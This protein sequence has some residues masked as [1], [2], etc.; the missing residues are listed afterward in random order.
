MSA[1]RAEK[2]I[3]AALVRK[4]IERLSR[5]K[6]DQFYPDTGP[7]RRELYKPHMACFA[8]GA[9]YRERLVLAANR[10]GKTESIGL[11]ELTLHLTGEYPT[12]WVGCRFDRPISAWACGDTGKTVREILQ[13]KLLGPIGQ[14]GTGLIPGDLIE[15]VT[16][17]SGVADSVDSIFVKHVSGL[18]SVLTLKSYDQREESFR[19]TEKDFILLDEEPPMGI[20]IECLM[21]TMTNNGK[22]L[23]TFTPL[24]GTS[25]VVLAFL[26]GGSVGAGIAQNKCVVMAEWDDVPHL[27]E[28]DKAEMLTKI[29][30]YQRDARS[31]GLPQLGAGAI[32]PVAESDFAVDDFPVPAHWLRVFGLD[33]GWR[34]TACVWAAQD[35][36]TRTWYLY[37][38]HYEGLAE[39]SEIAL[40][41]MARGSRI[42]GV[43]DPAARGR[44]PSDGKQLLSMYSDLGLDLTPADNSVHSGIN[45]TWDALSGGSLKVFKS[46]VNWF[47]EFRVYQRDKNGKI[48]KARDHLMD[49]C[50]TADT[51]V[52]TADG[53]TPWPEARQDQRFATMN[54]ATGEMEYQRA[55]E[56]VAIPWAGDIIAFNNK[57]ALAVT[58]NHRMVVRSRNDNYESL[59]IKRADELTVWD[60]IVTAPS[61]WLG[62]DTLGLPFDCDDEDLAELLG[63]WIAEGCLRRLT[64]NSPFQRDVLISQ[65]KP[66]GVRAIRCLLD[67]TPWR[68]GHRG[69]DFITTNKELYEFLLPFA[70]SANKR[71]PQCVR[72]GSPRLIEAFLRGYIAGDGWWQNGTRCSA[73]I[74]KG[75]ADDLQELY[76]KL[77][78]ASS[79]IVRAA[80]PYCIQGRYG[81]NTQDQ[82]WVLEHKKRVAL[83]RN[84]DNVPN[85]GREHYEGMVY[86]AQ[87]PNGTLIVRRNGK[88]SVTGNTRYLVMSGFQ[89]AATGARDFKLEWLKHYAKHDVFSDNL[90]LLVVPQGVKRG[91]VASV[92]TAIVIA[93]A[94]DG[95]FYLIDLF[96][97]SMTPGERGDLVIKLHRHYR[98]L[99]TIYD[100]VGW[101]IDR[102]HIMEV[103]R[104]SQYQFEPAVIKDLSGSVR[105]EDR[106]RRLAALFESGRIILPER[107][108]KSIDGKPVDLVDEFIER[109]YV[110]FPVSDRRAVLDCL[111]RIF[112]IEVFWPSGRYGGVKP[113]ILPEWTYDT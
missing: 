52:L 109:E 30:P 41:L 35:P 10:V 58:P 95:N 22:I 17:G 13:T 38:E 11:Y 71:V 3:Y 67:K 43:I 75:L 111:S 85:F 54:L 56:M 4:K 28:A 104:R 70:G 99:G 112:D 25:E 78:K 113:I 36:K 7:L 97:Q 60:K 65:V 31:K 96:S 2:L 61:F 48:V 62:R 64:E 83:L 101:E 23:L 44:S 59:R 9:H 108:E 77:G 49:A 14:R 98:P 89:I 94:A 79:L 66:D 5:R 80:Q 84:R 1:T 69:N 33:V 12:W 91:Y 105:Q 90:Y 68:W 39:P 93:A 47:A 76:L 73:T 57:T 107:M 50:F 87:V 102:G 74:S 24:E 29:P 46:L 6:I 100:Q 86:C 42:P 110:V 34:K 37:A 92:S 72:D 88:V 82:Y 16:P 51:E 19:G 53:W 103:M 81:T 63:W 26:P 21:R 15:R 40:A 45:A 18:A 8:A 55:L 27:T 106:I 20:Y 32:Y